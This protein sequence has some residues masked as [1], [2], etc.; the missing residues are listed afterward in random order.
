MFNP[1][2]PFTKDV[3]DQTVKR[4]CRYFVRNTYL[5]AFDHFNECIEGYFLFSH[6][7]DPSKAEAH[8]NSIGN[9]PHRFLYEWDKPAHRERLMMAAGNPKGY[10]IYSTYFFPDYKKKITK[11]LKDKINKY[12]YR[13]TDWKPGSGETVNIDFYLQFGLLYLTMKYAGQE[14]KI[15][16]ADIETL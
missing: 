11:N 15:K 2:Y 9:D 13:H 5:Q 4:G 8:F 12:M 16:F 6:Y 14:L 7:D 1:L 3:L 10:R